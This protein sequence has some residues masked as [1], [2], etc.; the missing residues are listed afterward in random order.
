MERWVIG[1]TVK[2]IR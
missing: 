1:H 2:R